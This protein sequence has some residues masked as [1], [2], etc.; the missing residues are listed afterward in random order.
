MF[1]S[2][3]KEQKS[4]LTV[5]LSLRLDCFELTGQA[6]AVAAVGGKPRVR[7]VEPS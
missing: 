6:A 1:A 7:G 4:G 2:I 3:E 5:P